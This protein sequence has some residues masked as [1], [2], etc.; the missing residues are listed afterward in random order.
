MSQNKVILLLG[1]NLGDKK[2]NLVTAKE[3]IKA[4][5]GK[6]SQESNILENK[7][8]DFTSNNLFL[9]QKIEILTQLNPFELLFTIKGIENK[10]GRVYSTPLQNEIHTDRLI[11]IDI[12]N[13]NEISINC[14]RLTIPHKQIYTREFVKSLFFY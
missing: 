5:I 13:F 10:I 6:I 11:D 12:L 14:K 9:N 2:K 3:F 7:A 8:E 1:T 4:E